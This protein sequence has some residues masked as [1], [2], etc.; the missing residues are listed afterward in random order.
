MAE[1]S[2]GHEGD[3]DAP[4][5][6]ARPSRE[7]RQGRRDRLIRA[8]LLDRF[9][10]V[11][12]LV[13]ITIAVQGLVDVRGSLLAQLFAH[14]ISGLALIAAVRASGA[15]RRWRHAVYVF[16]GVVVI[17]SVAT[18][19]W[20]RADGSS[21]VP[22]ETAW[23]L[24][25]AL[26]P[27]LIARRV[28]QHTVVTIQTIMGSVAAYLQL[29]V[30]Y[31]FLFQTIDAYTVTPFFG[32]DVSTTTYMY[33]SLVTISTVGFGDVAAVGD[34]GRMAAASEAVIGQV[35]LVTFVALIVSRFAAG[36]PRGSAGAP[37]E[38]RSGPVPRTLFEALDASRSNQAPPDPDPD[39]DEEDGGPD[40]A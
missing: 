34:L 14:A 10:L 33:F 7:S 3:A 5:T 36:M 2:S 15:R 40:R 22:P 26:T 28:L 13:L 24:A 1:P 23:L 32:E 29:A 37:V 35:Y 18:L 39:E 25:A 12:I 8:P 30:A 20:H 38:P 31:A 17:I 21:T 9:G 11:L 4:T 27:V 16:V 19:S 6:P